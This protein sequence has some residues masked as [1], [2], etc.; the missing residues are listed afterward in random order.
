[1]VT[2]TTSMSWGKPAAGAVKVAALSTDA[3]RIAIFRYEKGAAMVGLI[4][5]EPAARTRARWS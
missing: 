5:T 3:T 4:G 1:V 2:S